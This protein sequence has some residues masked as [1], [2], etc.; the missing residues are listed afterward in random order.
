MLNLNE[1]TSLHASLHN[2]S[3]QYVH[4]GRGSLAYQSP[5]RGFDHF[6]RFEFADVI[7]APAQNGDLVIA[8]FAGN[9]FIRFFADA[10]HI[11]LHSFANL[12]GKLSQGDFAL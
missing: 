7:D 12:G 9:H 8:G 2:M 3:Y 4:I 5:W 1:L 6:G 10:F 11:D